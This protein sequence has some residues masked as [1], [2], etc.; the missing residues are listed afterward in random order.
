VAGK[1]IQVSRLITAEL[2]TMYLF[3]L[4][5]L[6]CIPK[7]MA[8]QYLCSMLPTGSGAY[9][10]LAKHPHLNSLGVFGNIFVDKKDCLLNKHIQC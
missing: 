2:L 1:I 3:T 7:L 8:L 5:C 9:L 10:S 4:Q 6:L